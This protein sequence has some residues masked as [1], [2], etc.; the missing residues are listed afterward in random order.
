MPRGLRLAVSLFTVWR[1][2]VPEPTREDAARAMALLPLVGLAVGLVAAAATEAVRLMTP[3]DATPVFSAVAGIAALALLSR[4][5]HLDGLADTADGLGSLRPADEALAVMRRGDVGPLGVV[6]LVL[7]LVLQIGALATCVTV[8]RATY[9]FVTA[10]VTGR[11]AAVLSATPRTPGAGGGLGSL[12]AGSVSRRVALGWAALL[13]VAAYVA[14]TFDDRR[15]WRGGTHAALA[16]V[17]GLAFAHLLRHRIVR[18]L[19]GVNGDAFGA[20]VEVAT[21][22]ALFVSA[23]SILR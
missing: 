14:G 3:N 7:T 22:V 1:V 18:R 17:L 11:V 8:G 21:T 13:T 20:Q 9:A 15:G 6:T 5:L 2:D 12:V 10:V 16:V 23:L 4:G 19:G